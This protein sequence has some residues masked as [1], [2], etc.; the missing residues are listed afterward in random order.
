MRR[1][2]DAEGNCYDGWPYTQNDGWLGQAASNTSLTDAASKE[3][4]QAVKLFQKKDNWSV[5]YGHAFV[6][7]ASFFYLP[8][9]HRCIH[10]AACK[11]HRAFPVVQAA[12]R[13]ACGFRLITLMACSCRLLNNG[14]TFVKGSGVPISGWEC[15]E[16]VA[17][18]GKSA[19][20]NNLCKAACTK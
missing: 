19:P 5:A 2:C 11:L 7:C 15:K 3:V 1:T 10:S 4:R 18:N 17:G 12:P 13:A 20:N 8:L 14:A 9:V 6:R 16:W